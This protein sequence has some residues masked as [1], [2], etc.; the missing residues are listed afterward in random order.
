MNT[1]NILIASSLL[2]AT[3][4]TGCTPIRS[5]DQ[6]S[7]NQSSNIANPQTSPATSGIDLLNPNNLYLMKPMTTVAPGTPLVEPFVRND[8]QAESARNPM[9]VLNSNEGLSH[10]DA[11]NLRQILIKTGYFPYVSVDGTFPDGSNS[12]KVASIE[13]A[14]YMGSTVQKI[15]AITKDGDLA[16]LVGYK[17][18]AVAAAHGYMPD[19]VYNVLINRGLVISNESNGQIEATTSVLGCKAGSYGD[20]NSIKWSCNCPGDFSSWSSVDNVRA[21]NCYQKV[22]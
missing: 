1:K 11:V 8:P 20:S 17:I 16:R 12:F 2:V 6:S 15:K 3:L 18:N 21:P 14:D 4:I 22:Q 9:G 19:D 10:N 13:T 5:T 7:Q